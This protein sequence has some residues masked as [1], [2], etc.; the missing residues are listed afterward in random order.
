MKPLPC[1]PSYWLAL[2]TIFLEHLLLHSN[3]KK[4]LLWSRKSMTRTYFCFQWS[5][6][7]GK[8]CCTWGLLHLCVNHCCANPDSNSNPDSELFILYS[9][10]QLECKNP[11]LDSRKKGWIRILDLNPGSRFL[12][13][14]TAL[15]NFNFLPVLQMQT[16]LAALWSLLWPTGFESG[17]G[18]VRFGFRFKKKGMDSDSAGF[19][20]KV[21]EFGFGFGFEMSGFTHHRCQPLMIVRKADTGLYRKLAYPLQFRLIVSL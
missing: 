12:V 10:S 17:F 14:N 7:S 19:R 8:T 20:F 18:A 5:S 13:P 15:L 21:P 2:C 16:R 3:N 4:L 1:A 9:D 11:E 6:N